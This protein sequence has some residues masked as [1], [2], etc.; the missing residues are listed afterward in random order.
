MH[1][2]QHTVQQFEGVSQAEPVAFAEV[3]MIG[4]AAVCVGGAIR[5][6]HALQIIP[7]LLMLS[8]MFDHAITQAIPPTVWA[9]LLVVSA[10]SLGLGLRWAHVSEASPLS[11]RVTTTVSSRTLREVIVASALSYIAMA[12]MLLPPNVGDATLGQQSVMHQHSGTGVSS[13][14]FV[15]VVS[16]L[17]VWQLWIVVR[18][19]RTQMPLFGV[20]AAGMSAMLISM[21]TLHLF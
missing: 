17:I 5:A 11:T 16:S 18:S 13:S 12:W 9:I 1:P 6:R 14:A 19:F 15:V 10:M 3:V 20:E 8:A 4:S 7:A 21:L 2:S